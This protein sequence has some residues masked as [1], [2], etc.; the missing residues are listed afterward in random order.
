MILLFYF[1]LLTGIIGFGNG[2]SGKEYCQNLYKTQNDVW[3]LG[4]VPDSSF[5]AQL[6][7]IF[8]F[9]PFAEAL[10]SNLV[11]SDLKV[12]SAFNRSDGWRM[13]SA[14]FSTFFNLD[15]YSNYWSKFKVKVVPQ[16]NYSTCIVNKGSPEDHHLFSQLMQEQYVHSLINLTRVP[17][18]YPHKPDNISVLLYYANITTYE[19]FT[20]P[21]PNHALVRLRSRY[22]FTSL[23]S[24]WEQ[25][26]TLFHVYSSLKPIDSL[27]LLAKLFLENLPPDVVILS[28]RVDD[29]A[30]SS[31]ENTLQAETELHK[32]LLREIVLSECLNRYFL[33]KSDTFPSLYILSNFKP[34][35]KNEKKRS[36]RIMDDL[37]RLGLKKIF[38]RKTIYDLIIGKYPN[39][40]PLLRTLSYEHFSYVE[41]LMAQSSPCFAHAGHPSITSYMI[42][43]FRSL[44]RQMNQTYHSINEKTYRNLY[45]Y[46]DWGF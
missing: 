12:H 5:A 8:S 43:R 38:T 10:R 45:K 9:A 6:H 39:L 17:E 29:D 14:P 4:D 18:F 37:N 11:V 28:Y 23:F 32:T 33:L 2:I 41:M 40:V 44:D 46:R 31:P 36:K 26:P 20:F 27:Q 30:F 1:V 21:F 24:F 34:H 3:L 22:A 7:S 42:K 16:G 13:R 35:L 15:R 25:L 19:R